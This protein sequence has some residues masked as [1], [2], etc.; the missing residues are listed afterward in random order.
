[1]A[2]SLLSAV[3]AI[4]DKVTLS[5]GNATPEELAYLGTALD[6][7]GGRAT[8]YEVVEMGDVKMAELTTLATELTA[9]MNIDTTAELAAFVK[10]VDDKIALM[11]ASADILVTTS[12]QNIEDKRVASDTFITQAKDN[13][14]AYI[15]DTRN[16]ADTFITSSRNSAEAYITQTKDS[17]KTFIIDTR[18]DAET[19]IVNVK[20]DMS[21]YASTTLVQT[22]AVI[23]S[24]KTEAIL[25]VS[26][27]LTAL[28]ATVD[29]AVEALSSAAAEAQQQA[30]DGSLY[31]HFFLAHI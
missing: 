7:I 31:K 10:K 19:Y 12:M 9:A 5:A 28:K 14:E 8:V 15:T 25:A 4:K 27:K 17:A 29:D 26:D 20:N 1:M 3:Q 6:R 24:N 21:S 22:S 23:A 2:A 11:T 13:A 16:S 30:A 18:D